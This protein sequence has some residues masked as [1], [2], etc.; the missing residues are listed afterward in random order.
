MAAL[1]AL[2]TGS[3]LALAVAQPA[4]A[5]PNCN[6]PVPPPRCGGPVEPEPTPPGQVPVLAFDGARQVVYPHNGIHIWGW[7]ADDDAP[8]TPLTVSISIDGKPAHTMTAN[9][10]R[11]DVAAAYPKYG[12][13]HGF[14]VVL[15][16]SAAGHNVC[17]TA[18]SVGGGANKGV[19][20]Q[21]D[22]IDRFVAER[23]DYDLSARGWNLALDNYEHVRESNASAVDQSFAISGSTQ[24]NESASWTDSHGFAVSASTTF[25]TGIPVLLNG[26]IAVTV[27]ATST[28]T[29][30]GSTS[31]T[32]TLAWSKNIN[33]PPWSR[34]EADVLIAS[35]SV[36]V[37]YWMTGEFT[38][39]S[40]AKAPGAVGGWFTGVTSRNIQIETRQYYLDGTPVPPPA[41]P[42]PTIVK[43]TPTR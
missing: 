14:E 23:I 39:K 13:A 3:S 2:L 36:S 34:M 37:P 42:A 19:C 12:A 32:K 29:R 18:V 4:T 38:Y 10:V 27:S 16:A 28:F 6:V 1:G 40:G 11:T 17:V 24:V 25:E 20:R 33:M 8:T 41:N 9:Q 5:G 22:Q 26:Q 43:V 7:T 30:N 31:N 15:P 21:M 35:G